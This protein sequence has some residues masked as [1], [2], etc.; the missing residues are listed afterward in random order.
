MKQMVTV[1]NDIWRALWNT[2]LIRADK[3]L[4]SGQVEFENS[5]FKIVPHSKSK[6]KHEPNFIFKPEDY[7]ITWFRH[8]QLYAW[9]NKFITMEKFK[10]ILEVCV[11]SIKEEKDE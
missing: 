2:I 5:V 6:I 8:P 9:A 11:E 3:D 7:E 10:R 1:D 4:S